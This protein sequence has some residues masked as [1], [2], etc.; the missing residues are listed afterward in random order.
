MTIS[1]LPANFDDR[2]RDAVRLFW[3]TRA[4]GSSSQ[5]GTR[6]K[7]LSGKNLDGF[8][9]LVESIAAECGLPSESVFTRGRHNLQL[10]GYYRPSKNWDVLIVHEQRLIAVL[11][12]KSQVGSFGNNFNNRTEEAIGSASD[13]WVSARQNNFLPSNHVDGPSN[14]TVDPRQPFLGYLMMLEE[15]E[16]S[17]RPLT[18]RSA[19]YHFMPEF[20]GASYAERYRILCER[21]MEQQL[22]QAA[23]L[24]LSPQTEAGFGGHYRSLSVATSVRNL[25]SA[26]AG[27]LLSAMEAGT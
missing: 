19:H 18:L 11:E 6:G 15:C 25:F 7:V 2:V 9:A 23:S 13:L 16:D 10:P 26:L 1:I 3:A 12:F 21:L 20:A 17:T 27:T 8:I 22:Y 24:I 14:S 5:G 4:T